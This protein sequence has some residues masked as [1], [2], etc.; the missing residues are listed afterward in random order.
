MSNESTTQIAYA[1]T[2]PHLNIFLVSLSSNCIHSISIITVILLSLCNR[3]EIIQ[4]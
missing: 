1:P 2:K 3:V 4:I